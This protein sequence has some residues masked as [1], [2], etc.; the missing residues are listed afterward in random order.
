MSGFYEV[1]KLK[2]WRGDARLYKD[3]ETDK[4]IVISRADTFDRGDETMIFSS[5]SD[6]HIS[7]WTELYAGYGET[8]EV[9]LDNYEND[10]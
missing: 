2:G 4:Y 10:L 7:D 8:H 9:A 1:S 6:A 3:G 5:T